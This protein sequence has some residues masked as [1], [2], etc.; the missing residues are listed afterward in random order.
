MPTKVSPHN[1]PLGTNRHASVFGDTKYHM[2]CHRKP[3]LAQRSF[4][5]PVLAEH[6][7]SDIGADN[8]ESSRCVV[9]VFCSS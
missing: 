4:L 2:Q 7:N 3:R 1:S 6:L 8:L 5:H 9:K